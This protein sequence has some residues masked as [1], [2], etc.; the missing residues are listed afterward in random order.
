MQ[1]ATGPGSPQSHAVLERIDAEVGT[2][3]EAARAV[4]PDVVVAIVSD[5][6]FAPVSQ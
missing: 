2:I 3:V 1:H 6:G 5:H 4:E